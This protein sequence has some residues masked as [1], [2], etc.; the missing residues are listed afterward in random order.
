MTLIE[1]VKQRM[2]FKTIFSLLKETGSEWVNDK[3]PRLGAALAYYT[4]FSIA[5]LI[6]IAITI[7]GLVF[8]DSQAQVLSEVRKAMGDKGADA[9]QSMI[10]ATE[11]PAQSIVATILGFATLFFGAAGVVVQL[12]DA[13]NTIWDVEEAPSGG[14]I[15]F[16]K[17]YFLSF[18]VILGIGF[19]LLVSLLLEAGLAVVGQFVKDNM[20]ALG[21]LMQ[22]GGVAISFG[23]ITLLFAMLFKF[24]PDVE[25]AWRDVWVGA[26]LTSLLF[27]VGK[28]GL[29]LYLGKAA[30]ASAYGAA[31]SL[32]I[33][34]LWVYYSAQILFF[35]AEFTQVYSRRFG[36]RYDPL[37]TKKKPTPKEKLIAEIGRE[38]ERLASA[39]NKL[40][41]KPKVHPFES[42]EMHRRR[43]L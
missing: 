7:T 6:I 2:N 25:V 33:M 11:K 27:V 35:G 36:S 17:K 34:L 30:A 37:A 31:G 12:K 22:I 43:S 28:F 38:R 42:L 24:L 1:A 10:A 18:T 41:V 21:L 13:L 3:A 20:P 40:P 29:G 26:I 32:V 16:L 39:F 9:V 19:L 5:P 14:I 8:A 15:G 4:V 23:A